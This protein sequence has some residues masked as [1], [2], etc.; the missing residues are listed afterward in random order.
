MLA[1]K[2]RFLW[3][4]IVKNEKLIKE[5]KR[6]LEVFPYGVIIQLKN[7]SPEFPNVFT[8]EEFNRNVLD[9]KKRVEELSNVKIEFKD[10]DKENDVE[11]HS[12]SL[13]DYLKFEQERLLIRK[14]WWG[15]RIMILKE[16]NDQENRSSNYSRNRYN[17]HPYIEERV[18]IIR[19]LEV[20][21]QG[22][23]SFMHV[24][25]DATNI[26]KLEEAKNNI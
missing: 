15:H 23:D 5:L 18:Y 20:S 19:S 13:L 12:S 24:F 2:D 9:V 6:L 7:S 10:D 11:N 25:I 26:V 17:D 14:K 16:S 3:Y 8:N 21:W 4:I 22:Q 1:N